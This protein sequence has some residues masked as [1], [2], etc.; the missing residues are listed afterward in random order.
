MNLQNFVFGVYPYIALTVFIVGSWIRYDHEQYTW[1]TDSS[2]LLSKRHMVLA[3]N[4]FH[5]G[6]LSIFMGH[7]A[8]L[9]L[10]HG[11][12]LGLGISDLQHQW[13]AIVAGSVFG[14]MCL[15]G[16]SIL[17]LRRVFNPRVRAAGRK[18][19]II[20]L[21][22]LMLTLLFGLATL[23][24][25]VGHAG[26]GDPGVMLA[27]SGWVQSVLA[28]N[29]QPVLLDSVEPIFRLHMF[30][31][32]TVFLLFPFSRLVHAA[33]VPLTYLGRSYQIVRTKRRAKA[34]ASA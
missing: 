15:A 26:H 18:M 27:L 32:M 23:S 14:L 19:D 7:F 29:P 4:L 33:T 28:L 9:V 11:L 22:W 30:F 5:V 10:P 8:G 16:G 20:I 24:P 25:S 31:G 1:K 3:S 13:V 17:W 2:M 12:W 6:I 21:S 34:A